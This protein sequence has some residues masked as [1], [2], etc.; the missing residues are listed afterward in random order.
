MPKPEGMKTWTV[1]L[2]NGRAFTIEAQTLRWGEDGKFSDDGIWMSGSVLASN[3]GFSGHPATCWVVCPSRVTEHFTCGRKAYL[4]GKVTH[5]GSQDTLATQL[6]THS[7]L[8]YDLM[9]FI[10]R[11]VVMSPEQLLVTALWII[12]THCIAHVEQT[13]YLAVTSPEKRCGKSRLLETIE[14]LSARSWSAIMPSEAVVYRKVD[15]DVPTLLLDEVD[16]IFNPKTADRYE[17]LRALLN[18]GHRRGAMVPRCIG[19]STDIA[20]FSTFCPKVLAGIGT[21]PDTVADRAI[22]IRLERKTRQDTTSRFKRREVKPDADALRKRVEKWAKQHGPSLAK[23]EPDMPDQL[24]DRMQEGCEALVAIAEILRCGRQSREALVTLLEG[25]R[26]D[27]QESMRIR[28]LRD[29]RVVFDKCEARV[30]STKRLMLELITIDEAPW[31]T[32]YGRGIDPRDLSNLLR[33]YDIKST[34]V[35]LKSGPAKGYKRDAFHD[36]WERY[37]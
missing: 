15:I 8:V 31:A 33:H 25:E 10:R 14:M 20:E 36:A 18:N 5:A 21:L 32:Y 23:A 26:L 16:A 7:R 4:M 17:G 19:T 28:L 3:D 9:A 35:R 2:L 30:I 27:D 29:I 24:N 22:P 37:L 34:T 12:H 1:L 13:P 11:Y 6:R